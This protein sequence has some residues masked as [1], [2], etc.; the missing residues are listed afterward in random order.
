MTKQWI[1]SMAGSREHY[2]PARALHQ[3]GLLRQF[4]T[5]IWVRFGRRYLAQGPGPMRQ[6]AGRFHDDLPSAKVTSFSLPRL[7]FTAQYHVI[8]R[9]GPS[10]AQSFFARSGPDF[11]RRVA[12]HMRVNGLDREPGV[13]F[14]FKPASLETFQ[15]LRGSPMTLVL[16]QFDAAGEHNAILWAEHER[17]PGWGQAPPVLTED[18]RGRWAEEW[19][20][21]DVVFVNSEW[22]KRAIVKQGVP[23]EKI[24]IGA[25]AYEARIA[26]RPREPR[27]Q[28]SPLRVLWVGGVT[29]GKGIQYLIEAARGMDPN[30]FEFTIVGAVGI[31]RK[32]RD[33]A[34]GN[35]RFLG[36]LPRG[37]VDRYYREADVYVLPTM[38]DNWPM[39]QLEAMAHGLPVI[40]STS[41]GSAVDHGVDGL[42][43]P[44]G[45]AE[46][47]RAALERLERNRDEA[48]AM[49]R[50]ALVKARRFSLENYADKLIGGVEA[51]LKAKEKHDR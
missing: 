27:S 9:L 45:D 12:A 16:D 39:T 4:Y 20:L 25:L 41:C 2:A 23:A 38:S 8:G 5:D 29:L 48:A 49:S 17:W 26:G 22:T 40:I 35:M 10:A 33:L 36:Q 14:G 31:T 30:R 11:A 50:A 46:A 42:I 1:V 19:R 51:A 43:V 3:R 21:A 34:P 32:G 15:A 6:L 47:L 18:L 44:A 28:G 13:F 24:A 37:E 7:L